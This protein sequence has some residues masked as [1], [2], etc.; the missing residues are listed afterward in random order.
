MPAKSK[1]QYILMK[2]A[3]K[4]KIKLP[5]LSRAQAA[6]YTQGQSYNELPSKKKKKKEK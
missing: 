5:G 2:L 3:E 6:E 1:Q 4:G